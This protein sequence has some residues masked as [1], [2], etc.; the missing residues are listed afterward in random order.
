MLICRVFR[1][2]TGSGLTDNFLGDAGLFEIDFHYRI[3]SFGS[4]EE[5]IKY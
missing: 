1:D 2:A 4:N 5:Y 3:D